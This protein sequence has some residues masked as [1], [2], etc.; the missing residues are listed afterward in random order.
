MVVAES[1][2]MR[3]GM[4]DYQEPAHVHDPAQDQEPHPVQIAT[5]VTG[6]VI[7]AKDLFY[8]TR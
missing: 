8:Y 3:H 6:I 5:D 2:E 4:R 1:G 7:I